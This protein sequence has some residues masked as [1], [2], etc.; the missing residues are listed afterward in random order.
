MG[1]DV[2]ALRVEGLKKTYGN[3]LLALDGPLRFCGP[4]ARWLLPTF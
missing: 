2:P 4:L 1:G 3:G